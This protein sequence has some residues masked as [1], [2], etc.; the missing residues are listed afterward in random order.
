MSEQ[1]Q[2]AFIFAAGSGKRMMPITAD[3]PKPLVKVNNL[4]IIDYTLKS[5]LKIDSIQKI[6]INGYYLS[7][8]I[9]AYIQDANNSKIIFSKEP[10]KLETGG[11][12]L[13]AIDKIDLEK[14]L[15][16]INGDLM[17]L[18]DQD[19]HF[20]WK[21]WFE[22]KMTGEIDILLGL[23]KKDEFPGY[24][25]NGD[26]DYQDGNLIC[27]QGL[28]MTHAFVGIQ[29]IDP[30]ILNSPP[31]DKCFSMSYFYGREINQQNLVNKVR[32][33]ELP[34]KYFHVSEPKDIQN[35]ENLINNYAK[36]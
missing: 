36:G 9:Q 1:L 23:K 4:P 34:G 26:F 16:I 31:K 18:G 22:L 13:F 33:V 20:I 21:R 3:T 29:I 17:W 8:K 28:A 32:G 25:G 27:N 2:Q 11:G 10:E 35:T 12:L 14:P 6:I 30:K 7:D 19:L 5:L 15:L 24:K